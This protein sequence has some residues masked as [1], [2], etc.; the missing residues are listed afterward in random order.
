MVYLNGAPDPTDLAYHQPVR[1]S[2]V[3]VSEDYVSFFMA[4]GTLSAFFHLSVVSTWRE[5][6]ESE[7]LPN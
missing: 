7:L 5:M 2:R 4:D 1:A 3:E 6:D